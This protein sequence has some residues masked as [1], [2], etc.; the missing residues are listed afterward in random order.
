MSRIRIAGAAALAAAGA[1]GLL[2]QPASAAAPEISQIPRADLVNAKLMIPPVLGWGQEC[3]SGKLTF[4]NGTFLAGPNAQPIELGTPVYAN[5][6]S[7]VRLETAL[8]VSCGRG[9]KK[10]TQ[11]IA[12]DRNADKAISYR[13]M[14][15]GAQQDIA[16]VVSIAPGRDNQGIDA[17]VA[18]YVPAGPKDQVQPHQQT[19]TYVWNLNKI[20][21]R[22][23]PTAFAARDEAT[24]LGVTATRVAGKKF[25]VTVTNHGKTTAPHQMVF[26]YGMRAEADNADA[27]MGCDHP[28]L[29]TL[30][31]HDLG[32]A[33]GASITFNFEVKSVPATMKSALVRV[34]SSAGRPI[35]TNIN[36]NETTFA[37][38]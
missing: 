22:G 10:V 8:P 12:L 23:G 13:G 35:D 16:T 9:D 7:D 31:E 27:M 38:K 11:V 29:G 36:D 3:S 5:L 37:V 20:I 4:T 24:D 30:C 32:L 6:D 15:V 21:Q 25:T 28:E 17:R 1:L 26:V 2:A 33:A 18:D 19:R 34:A 14:V